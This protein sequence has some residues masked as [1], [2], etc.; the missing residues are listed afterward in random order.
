MLRPLT[1]ACQ[2]FRNPKNSQGKLDCLIFEKLFIHECKLKLNTEL[3]S[4]PLFI[5]SLF[6]ILHLSHD[7]IK[8][9]WKD[10][11]GQ[12]TALINSFA[13]FE[14][15]W[16]FPLLMTWQDEDSYKSWISLMNFG[17]IP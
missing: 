5:Y 1:L 16:Q 6:D 3:D 13:H 12:Q 4:I 17:G 8:N 14:R 10:N 11:Q 7:P 2:P 15:F 9:C